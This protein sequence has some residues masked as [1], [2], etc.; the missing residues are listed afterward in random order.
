M[1]R[2]TKE[3]LE[4]Q[5]FTVTIQNDRSILVIKR[6]TSPV[7]EFRLKIRYNN[8]NTFSI[9]NA[10]LLSFETKMLMD[11]IKEWYELSIDDIKPIKT[12]DIITHEITYLEKFEADCKTQFKR[13]NSPAPTTSKQIKH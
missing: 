11:L 6:N 2:I 12:I 4:E 1:K 7:V 8:D 9:H 3:W 13:S 5:D 10:R